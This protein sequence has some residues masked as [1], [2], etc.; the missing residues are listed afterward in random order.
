MLS[1]RYPEASY[2]CVGAAAVAELEVVDVL[3]ALDMEAALLP[4]RE[5]APRKDRSEG[6]ELVADDAVLA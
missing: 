5:D 1:S 3:G 4:R 6:V 2:R